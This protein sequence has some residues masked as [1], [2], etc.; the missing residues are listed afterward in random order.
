MHT[1]NFWWALLILI[2]ITIIY[3]TTECSLKRGKLKAR[4]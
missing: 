3:V 2:V 4:Y 1:K